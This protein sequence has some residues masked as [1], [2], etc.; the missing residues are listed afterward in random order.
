MIFFTL[1]YIYVFLDLIDLL[2]PVL[3]P[4]DCP[5]TLNPDTLSPKTFVIDE[6]NKLTNLICYKII[7]FNFYYLIISHI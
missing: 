3:D 5:N 7:I 6:Q 1:G 2:D 4:L